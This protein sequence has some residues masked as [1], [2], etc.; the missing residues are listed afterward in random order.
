M[1]A[2]FYRAAWALFAG[3]TAQALPPVKKNAKTIASAPYLQVK[4]AY[5]DV[6][7]DLGA[8]MATVKDK[9]SADAAA[10]TVCSLNERLIALR[11]VVQNLPPA[12]KSIRSY[13]LK[14]FDDE[15]NKEIAESGVGKAMELMMRSD[16]P[17]YGSTAL[18]QA[19]D[20]FFNTLCSAEL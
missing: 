9:D 5:L 8:C 6:L 20:A 11:K 17:C 19:L 3:I 14:R 7:R 16:A 2:F 1:K 13:I 18:Q 10:A 12:P 15:Q 4:Q